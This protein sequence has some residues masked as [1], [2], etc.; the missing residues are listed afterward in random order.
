[1]RIAFDAKRYYHNHTGLGNYSRTLIRGLQQLEPEMDALLYDAKSFKRSFALGSHARKDG[2][3]LYHG[4]SN[5]LPFDIQR[6]G[7]PSLVTMHDVC[8]RTYPEMYHLIDRKLY[9]LKY[10]WSARHADMVLAISES[11]KRDVM[12]YYQVP[13][14]RIRVIYQPVNEL[15]YKSLSH[16]EA[17][18]LLRE[19]DMRIPQDYMLYV[20]S[21]NAR[22]N[23]MGVVQAM[24]QLPASC[25]L[26]LVVIGGGRE[27]KQQVLK[28]IECL[29]LQDYIIWQKCTDHHLLHALYTCA[30][31]FVYP[32][33][34][35]GF[36]L[37]VVEAVL[38]GCPVLT[39]NVSSL[40][41]AGGPDT[42]QA[43]P[44]SIDDIAQKMEQ[45][46]CDEALR[47][48]MIE[49]A[50]NYAISH[51]SPEPLFRQVLNL[52]SEMLDLKK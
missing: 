46:L 3:L 43:V 48:Q 45:G 49:G 23:L 32:S 51:F 44:S 39:S 41:E 28:E 21:V 26:P 52:Y 18:Q 19:S 7:V 5:E 38:S 11:T 37:P 27:Y 30:R 9:D 33:F 42:L 47:T 50:R 24:A 14:E 25:R 16:D 12:N 31:L 29:G 20:G 22:K 4:L 35:E 1:M 2:A 15:Y 40:P 36:G 34:Y 17:C 6:S 10:G 13:E 8:W